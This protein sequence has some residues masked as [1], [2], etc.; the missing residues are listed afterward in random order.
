MTSK[1]A[2]GLGGWGWFFRIVLLLLNTL[3]LA[4]GIVIVAVLGLYKNSSV[5]DYVKN[6]QLLDQLFEEVVL[7]GVDVAL[8]V[9]GCF[10]MC[11][12]L[13]GIIVACSMHFKL[14]L[15]YEVLLF[16]IFVIHLVIFLAFL[17]MSPRYEENL[18]KELNNII[19]KINNA[20][21][22]GTSI[23]QMENTY[24]LLKAVS[25]SFSCCGK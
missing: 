18:R 6:N 11:V 14:I 9:L 2:S 23:S 17:I 1:K 15:L 19:D 24:T 10:L 16:F 13:Y 7:S 4:L 22:Y 8:L 20:A 5:F 25:V 3:A 21:L 12:G